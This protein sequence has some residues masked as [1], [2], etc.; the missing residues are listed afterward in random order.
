MLEATPRTSTNLQTALL[1][2]PF[3][4]VQVARVEHILADAPSALETWLSSSELARLDRL[5]IQNRRDQYLSGHWLLRCLLSQHFGKPPSAWQLIERTNLPPALQN[6]D[7]LQTSISHSGDWIAAAIANDAI[8]I[9]LEQRRER[10]GLMRFQHLL[11]THDEPPDSLDSD[12]LLQRWVAKEAWVKRHHGSA[13][14]EQLA[15][16]ELLHAEP[17][18][19]D[20]QLFSTAAF[21][22]AISA[23]AESGNWQVDLGQNAILQTACWRL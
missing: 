7:L 13:L 23:Q 20:V 17:E 14:P 22:L 12:Q 11:L 4:R 15:E 3:L 9:D 16:L 6:F 19:A 10:A 21:H 8:G 2:K 18:T 1:N 5:K